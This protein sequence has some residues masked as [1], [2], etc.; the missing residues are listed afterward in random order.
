MSRV[1][2]M[3]D[4]I[5]EFIRDFVLAMENGFTNHEDFEIEEFV[6]AIKS[7]FLSGLV[8]IERHGDELKLAANESL[9]IMTCH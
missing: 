8:V 2:E 7:L 1:C 6:V 5:E 3:N 9:E 4:E